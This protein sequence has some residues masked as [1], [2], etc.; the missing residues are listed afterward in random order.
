MGCPLMISE[1]RF[2]IDHGVIHDRETGRHLTADYERDYP[3]ELLNV[4]QFLECRTSKLSGVVAIGKM[5]VEKL[6]TDNDRLLAWQASVMAEAGIPPV[7]VPPPKQHWPYQTL[8]ARCP[9]CGAS[10]SADFGLMPDECGLC[11]DL[12]T[13]HINRI[14]ADYHKQS[15]LNL[16]AKL[17]EAEARIK[18]FEEADTSQQPYEKGWQAGRDESWR[19]FQTSLEATISIAKTTLYAIGTDLELLGL[20]TT[21]IED[22]IA[23]LTVPPQPDCAACNTSE[24]CLNEYGICS[25][26]GKP[27]RDDARCYR[28]LC[29]L[30]HT[31]KCEKWYP[32]DGCTAEYDAALAAVDPE[33]R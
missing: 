1:S 11:N 12:R 10:M 32:K 7:Y 14:T 24:P 22:A 2:F 6:K 30:L 20:D 15:A 25:R 29:D 4:L 31:L 5:A 21:D 28:A 23:K 9:T 18:E 16:S 19:A 3:Q 17:K 8:T 33:R 13:S 26:K 27:A